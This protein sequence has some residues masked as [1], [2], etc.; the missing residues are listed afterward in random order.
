MN[1]KFSSKGLIAMLVFIIL[2]GNASFVSAAL[3]D[4][5]G[6]GELQND[7]EPSVSSPNIID[8]GGTVTKADL[9]NFLKGIVDEWAKLFNDAYKKGKAKIGGNCALAKLCAL[10]PKLKIECPPCHTKPEEDTISMPT[11]SHLEFDFFNGGIGTGGA[12]SGADSWALRLSDSAPQET[13][14]TPS[15]TTSVDLE[16]GSVEICPTPVTKECEISFPL[17][18]FP[19][20]KQEKDTF[21]NYILKANCDQACFFVAAEPDAGCWDIMNCI[22]KFGNK[23]VELQCKRSTQF[24]C[25]RNKNCC[26]SFKK[27][28]GEC[29]PNPDYPYGEC[30]AFIMIC[31]ESSGEAVYDGSN[32]YMNASGTLICR[33]KVL[34]MNMVLDQDGNINQLLKDQM[35]P[36]F[37]YH[38]EATFRGELNENPGKCEIPEGGKCDVDP[39]S[40]KQ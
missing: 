23:N 13:D 18:M 3:M 11:D 14:D 24:D 6:L 5:L 32:K 15:C 31:D 10:V 37:K 40:L 36:S 7:V 34:D 20:C 27:N 22:M 19:N 2:L 28:T 30:S 39:N 29:V 21:G 33:N 25:I 26:L 17:E 12:S 38:W 35:E 1:I 4:I 9:S 16:S 8:I